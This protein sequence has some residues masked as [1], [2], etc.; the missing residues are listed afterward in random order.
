MI[1]CLATA[2]SS[3]LYGYNINVAEMSLKLIYILF[4]YTP[5]RD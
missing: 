5:C 3:F 2:N 1:R 4:E